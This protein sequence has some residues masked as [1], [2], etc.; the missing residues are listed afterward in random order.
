MENS[1]LRLDRMGPVAWLV[2]DRPDVGNAMDGPMM[3]ALPDAWAELD[4]DAGVRC[5]VVTGEGR[6]FQTGLDMAALAGDPAS[7]REQARQTKAAALR[8][9]NL[10]NAVATPVVAAVNGVCAGGG[11]HFVVDADLA[12]ASE[13]ATFLD[14]HVS[15][16]QA[17]AWETVGLAGR[18]AFGTAAR[19]AFVGAH[20]R[21][22]AHRACQLGL[23]GEVV[24]AEDLT[25]RAQRLAEIVADLDVGEA[26]ARRRTLWTALEHGRTD[27]RRVAAARLASPADG[28]GDRAAA[29]H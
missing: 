27:A 3:S 5:I 14:P 24:A 11:L 7:L 15:V 8:L 28:V 22:S 6:A 19:S 12:I 20:E 4:A 16:G 9:T 17:S 18:G 10:H 29:P 21:L 2:F 23:V 1:G 13:R 26:R 25:D